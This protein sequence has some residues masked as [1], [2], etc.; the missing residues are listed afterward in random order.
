MKMLKIVANGLPL[1]QG[2]CVIDFVPIQR[3]NEEATE[4]MDCIYSD[5]QRHFYLNQAIAVVGVNASGK[6]TVL[7][8]IAFVCRMVNN[9]AINNIEYREILND[10]APTDIDVWLYS[11]VEQAVCHLHTTI[12]KNG[13]KYIIQDEWVKAKKIKSISS[14]KGLF[15]F[16]KDPDVVR[17]QDEEF[18]LDDVSIMVAINKRWNEN[19]ILID[20][21]DCTDTNLFSITDDCPAELIEFFDPTIEYLRTCKKGDNWI[22]CLKFKGKDEIILNRISALNKYLSSGTI[23]GL[24]VFK[25]AA[26]TFKTGGCLIV[27]EIENHFNEEIVSTLIRFYMDKKI[28]PKGATL[29]FST[30]YSGLLDEFDRSD[31]IYVTRNSDGITAENLS[32]ALNR[33][34]I[35]KSEVFR[36]GYLYGTTPIYELYMGLKKRLMSGD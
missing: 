21:L 23:K 5:N 10:T 30:H 22:I 15:D 2:T 13:S 6:T 35:K 16:D 11:E 20:M 29:I 1:F 31:N 19:I 34:D 8:L 12:E 26:D 7:K 17:N 3:I 9:E 18:L 27:D 14:K 32:T 25:R 24:N 4:K 33:N 36:S 28:N